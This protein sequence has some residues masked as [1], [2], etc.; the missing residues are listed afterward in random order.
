MIA[1]RLVE[2]RAIAAGYGE[3]DILKIER[4]AK[5]GLILRVA[6]ADAPWPAI[7]VA[8]EATPGVNAVKDNLRSWP[9]G[10]AGAV[11]ELKAMRLP[12]VDPMPSVGEPPQAASGM[13]LSLV[14][15]R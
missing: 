15:F 12:M 1:P 13:I 8:A 2:L 7:R 9:A 4:A 11:T 10:A 6:Q 3:A 14:V 5:T